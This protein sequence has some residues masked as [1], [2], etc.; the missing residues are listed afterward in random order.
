MALSG[1]TTTDQ[2]RPGSDSTEG[3]LRIPQS[4]SSTGNWPSNC[5]VSFSGH[6]LRGSSSPSSEVELVYSTVPAN[7][8]NWNLSDKS[9]HVSR[10]LFSILTDLN[11]AVVRMV[12]TRF[13][14]F[15]STSPCIS[16]LVTVPSAPI[17]ICINVTFMFH[18][19]FQFSSS[20]QPKQQVF[21]FCW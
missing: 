9:P 12:S 18:I 20:G 11:N 8:A 3:V 4:F 10:T 15:K 21:F 19:Y 6:S 5:L 13:L 17:T 7:L 2:S 14:I 1:A 16:L